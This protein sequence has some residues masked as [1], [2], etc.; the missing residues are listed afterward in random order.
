MMYLTPRPDHV[1]A[2][3]LIPVP[4]VPI[5]ELLLPAVLRDW[6]GFFASRGPRVPDLHAV[7]IVDY[8]NVH[9]VGHNLFSS[10]RRLPLHQ[11]LVDPLLFAG[12]LLRER[13]ARQRLDQPAAVL[14]RV[15]VFRGQPSPEHDPHGYA[16]SLAQQSQWQRDHRVTVTLRP[17]K[18]DYQRDATGGFV[19]DIYGQRITVG[20]PREK[21]VDVLCALAAVRAA[22]EPSADLVIVASSDTD[23]SPVL[24]EVRRL[25]GAK[26]ETFCW[27]DE[28]TRRGYQLHP[29]DRSRPAWNTRLRELDFRACTDPTDYR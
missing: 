29:M 2:D 26:V 6:R 15:E 24:D 5:L 13:N 14:H 17:L 10:T 7:V 25:G 4:E 16:R 22:Q 21:G 12:R 20:P 8:Q 18:Y 28:E 19:R 3:V 11:T 23:L 1:R 9:L 27:W